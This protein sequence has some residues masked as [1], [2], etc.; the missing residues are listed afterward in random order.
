[1]K[2]YHGL[3]TMSDAGL[4]KSDMAFPQG[5]CTLNSEHS[6]NAEEEDEIQWAGWEWS[7]KAFW[8][9]IKAKLTRQKRRTTILERAEHMQRLRTVKKL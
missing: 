8:E 3:G 7:R 9:D 4:C 5:S 2:A 6:E 1:M